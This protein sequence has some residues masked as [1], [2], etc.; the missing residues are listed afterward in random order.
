[1]FLELLGD[2]CSNP[3]ILKIVFF[4]KEIIKLLFIII[5][6]GAI[7]MLSFDMAKN[8]INGDDGT[9]R[10]NLNIFIRRI[11][12][13]V[14][15]FLVP[16]IVRFFVSFLNENISIDNNSFL[17]CISVDKEMIDKQLKAYKDNCIKEKGTWDS[18]NETCSVSVYVPSVVIN[19]K[20]RSADSSSFSDNIA[21]DFVKKN[22]KIYYYKDGEKVKGKVEVKNG[23]QVDTYWFNKKS[24]ALEGHI[25]GITYIHQLD[26]VW[27]AKKRRYSKKEYN[28][29]TP[30]FLTGEP[31]GWKACGIT[32]SAM[33]I[34]ALRGKLTLPTEFNSNKYG[35]NGKGSNYDVAVLTARKYNLKGKVYRVLSEE[36]IKKH[37]NKGHF[38][39]MGVTGSIYGGSGDH[40]GGDTRTTG[41]GHFIL[42]HGYKDGKYAIADPNNASQTYVTTNRLKSYSTFADHQ[43]GHPGGFDFKQYGII[44]KK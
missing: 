38:I 12:M 14:V 25:L 19:T 10:K 32:S 3:S 1:M 28:P 17:T 24:G 34:T 8:V 11:I 40:S 20:K 42:L 21:K 29:N 2:P 33:A 6:I 9:Q 18:I 37:I 35:F 5:P 23:K 36:E 31:L 41:G 13:L 27:D 15:V 26:G 16:T 22:N 7:A 30:N 39:V 43:G 44:Y 4:V